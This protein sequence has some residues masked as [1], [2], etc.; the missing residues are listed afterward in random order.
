MRVF[1]ALV[2]LASVA[3][4]HCGASPVDVHAQ[5]TPEQLTNPAEPMSEETVNE[6]AR[7][8]QDMDGPFDE[9]DLYAPNAL[10]DDEGYPFAE[11]PEWLDTAATTDEELSAAGRRYGRGF[12][13]RGFKGYPGYRSFVYAPRLKKLVSI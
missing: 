4:L 10:A 1:T 8:E 9:M 11:Y 3:A 6:P 7:P 12:G 13:Y 2:A 5:Q